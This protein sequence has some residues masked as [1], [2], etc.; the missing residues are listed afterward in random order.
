MK[1]CESF[2]NMYMLESASCFLLCI[3]RAYVRKRFNV[4]V[5]LSDTKKSIQKHEDDYG[6]EVNMRDDGSDR[7]GTD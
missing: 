6:Y 1:V 4:R 2:R 5:L 7:N 3:S